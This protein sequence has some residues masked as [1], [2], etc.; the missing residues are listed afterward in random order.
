MLGGQ[1]TSWFGMSVQNKLLGDKSECA[2]HH[3]NLDL[4]SVTV[5]AFPHGNSKSEELVREDVWR[6][7]FTGGIVIEPAV[8][9][10]CVPVAVPLGSIHC[11]SANRFPRRAQR[12][13]ISASEARLP[14][15]TAGCR[16]IGIRCKR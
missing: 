6:L 1:G 5:L 12:R 15:S 16:A 14:A 9:L 11:C 13:W 3:L 8:H 7:D 10:P 4:M 2:C